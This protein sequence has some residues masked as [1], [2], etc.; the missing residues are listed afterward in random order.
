MLGTHSGYTKVTFQVKQQADLFGGLFGEPQ[1]GPRG[2]L[3]Y[4]LTGPFGYLQ[5]VII[6]Y[7][8]ITSIFSIF[9]HLFP[10]YP[11]KPT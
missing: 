10:F 11:S 5:K 1:G 9:Q 4:D 3:Y 6:L 8:Q 2:V 7:F